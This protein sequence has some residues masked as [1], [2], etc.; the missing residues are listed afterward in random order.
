MEY[1]FQRLVILL[2]WGA[3]GYAAKP[4]VKISDGKLLGTYSSAAKVYSFKGIPYAAPPIGKLR[5]ESPQPESAWKGV[6]NATAFGARCMQAR[7]FDDMIF[8]DP[9]PSENCLSVNVWTADLSKTAKLPVMFWIHGGGFAAGSSSEPRQDGENL[10]KRG[11]V[12]VSLNYR[13]NVFGFFAHPELTK[14]SSHHAS[15]N[16]GL[17]DMAAA[18][19]WVRKNIEAF[20]GD[21]AKVTIFGESAGSWA[22]SELM[23]SPSS[24]DLFA[25]AIGESGAA[26]STTSLPMPPL[27]E[28]EKTGAAFAESIHCPTLA[29]LRAMPAEQ[30]TQ[31]SLKPSPEQFAPDIDGYFLP[32]QVPAIY[33]AGK[34]AHVPLLAGWNLNEGGTAAHSKATVESFT[35]DAQKNFGD[36]AAQF[37]KVYPAG[38]LDEAKESAAALARDQ[39]IAFA[40]WKWIEAQVAT[41]DSQV[42][43]YLFTHLLPPPADAN[44][45]YHSAD[46]EFVFDDL[47]N[48]DLKWRESDQQLANL[49]ASYWTNFAKTGDPNRPGL[50]K[51]PVFK[52]ADG[53]PIMQLDTTAKAFSEEHRDR[54]EFLAGK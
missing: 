42:Y 34:Q 53:Y 17:E 12:V 2:A 23:A 25:R 36:R 41:G 40:T 32:E 30:L 14:E 47:A 48:K 45:A 22:V 8:R 7:I 6:K 38:T 54:Y 21:P 24:K 49:M 18:L 13:L 3:V 29:D 51:W 35:A 44:G 52:A 39:F 1:R 50:P 27:L 28:A 10:A 37:L 31:A 9:G 5:W 4:L 15:G 26:F 33:A 19:Q 46:I 43:R 20:G 11:V 16:Y